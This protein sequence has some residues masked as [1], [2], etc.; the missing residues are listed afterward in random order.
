MKKRPIFILASLSA[1]LIVSVLGWKAEP[2]KDC[3]PVAVGRSRDS[4]AAGSL[5]EQYVSS[6]YEAAGLRQ[7]DLGFGIF[8]K[9]LVGYL[10]LKQ[11]HKVLKSM[12]TIVDFTRSSREKRLWVIDLAEKKLLFNTLVAHGQGSGDD[13]AQSFSNTEETH[14]SSLG[15]YVTDETYQG[16]HGLSL[17]LNGLDQGYNSNARQ[18]AIVL[19]GAEYVSQEFINQHG[20]LG[21]SY[22]CPAV[23]VALTPQIIDSVKGK[24]CLFINGADPLY[25]SSFLNENA[26]LSQLS[27]L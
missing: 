27:T 25:T 23:P 2:F 18:R 9:A 24:S 17:R 11:E 22:G 7:S 13:M 26:L 19:H 8:Q 5:L 12:L 3:A 10:N 16:K 6:V 20:R 14:Q 21:R 1:V 4:V 15:F